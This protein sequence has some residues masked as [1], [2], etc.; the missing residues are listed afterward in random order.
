MTVSPNDRGRMARA[1]PGGAVFVRTHP[2]GEVD[3]EAARHH[4]R[5]F[6][7]GGLRAVLIAVLHG[8]EADRDEQRRRVDDEHAVTRRQARLVA[9]RQRGTQSL[10]FRQA[11]LQQ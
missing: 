7:P 4:V 3:R 11:A 8:H 5:G 2:L 10:N 9:W 1:A 6:S